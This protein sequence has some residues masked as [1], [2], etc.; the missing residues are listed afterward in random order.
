MGLVVIGEAEPERG[1][2]AR[3]VVDGQQLPEIA[4]LLLLIAQVRAV[5]PAPIAPSPNFISPSQRYDKKT[6]VRQDEQD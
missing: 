4:R 3:F 5:D 6:G 2:D 1:V